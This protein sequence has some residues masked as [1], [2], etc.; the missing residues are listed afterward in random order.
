MIAID[1]VSESVHAEDSRDESPF[2][3]H[4]RHGVTAGHP[5]P[6][7]R[8]APTERKQKRNRRRGHEQRRIDDGEHGKGSRR[9][10]ALVHVL[11]DCAER[12][13]DK[14]ANHVDAPNDP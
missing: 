8:D 3:E 6:M 14:S 4:Q 10:Q 1:V 5:L 12:R 13:Q 2:E 9:A 7:L 11:D